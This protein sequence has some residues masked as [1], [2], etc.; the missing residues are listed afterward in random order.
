MCVYM[1]AD[2]NIRAHIFIYIYI[3]C[4][5]REEGSR[6]SMFQATTNSPK[7]CEIV[8]VDWCAL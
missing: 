7:C 5:D 4:R 8:L 2:T 1:H 3:F 6:A